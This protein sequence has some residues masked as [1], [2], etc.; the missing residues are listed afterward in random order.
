MKIADES[1]FQI[2]FIYRHECKDYGNDLIYYEITR[3]PEPS[4]HALVHVLIPHR[5]YI[6]IWISHNKIID[7]QILKTD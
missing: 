1:N 7:R 2:V 6:L 4:G 3:D 5:A